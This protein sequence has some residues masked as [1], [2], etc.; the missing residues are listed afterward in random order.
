VGVELGLLYNAKLDSVGVNRS[1]IDHWKAKFIAK[2]YKVCVIA[3]EH[4][5]VTK[6]E[7]EAK[8]KLGKKNRR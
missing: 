5:A 8:K 4:T 3:Q 1:N 2:G 6:K 7:K